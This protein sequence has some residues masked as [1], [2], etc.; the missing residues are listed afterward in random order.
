MMINII[1]GMHMVVVMA[2]PVY[3]LHAIGP[4]LC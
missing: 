1:Y 4:L 3:N 2:S